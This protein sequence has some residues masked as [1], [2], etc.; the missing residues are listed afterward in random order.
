MSGDAISSKGVAM[1]LTK[2]AALPYIA[3]PTAISKTDPT[4]IT[5]PAPTP[6]Q[7]PIVPLTITAGATTSIAISAADYAKLI[8]Q[9]ATPNV[10]F[11]GFVGAW[12]S[13]NGVKVATPGAPGTNLF[14]V[15]V[16]STGFG[17]AP[18]ASS[19]TSTVQADAITL[20]IGQ[21]VRVNNS[22]F[23]ALDGKLFTIGAV[24]AGTFSL[25]G[26]DTTGAAGN[27]SDDAQVEIWDST[28]LVRMCLTS[29]AFN[30]ETP[31]TT[32]VGTYCNPSA[33][34]PAVATSAGTA[35]LGGWI[36]K[37]DA[38]YRELK[39]ASNDAVQRI[40]SI[41]LPQSQGEIVAPITFSS[42]SWDIPLDGGMAFT[43]N[44]ALGSSPVHLF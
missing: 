9:G 1:F 40:F 7:L 23:S 26:A 8:A 17:A 41:V 25:M 35:T 6:P 2:A 4:V 43:A 12:I 36:D 42:M 39:N 20:A 32:N 29:F 31:G 3:D 14:T 15:A 5:A 10:T 21:L 19:I 28:D 37:D 27:M 33:T 22:G 24:G 38:G 16:A 18:A 34:L 44:G 30:P 11:A 13:M